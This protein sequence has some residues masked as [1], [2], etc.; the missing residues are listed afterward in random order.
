MS[1]GRFP[2]TVYAVSWESR[3][4]GEVVKRTHRAVALLATTALMMAMVAMAGAPYAF[5]ETFA[6]TAG[7]TD[8]HANQTEAHIGG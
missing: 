1:Q 6:T 7:I 3:K 8:A 2:K 5:A 4:G